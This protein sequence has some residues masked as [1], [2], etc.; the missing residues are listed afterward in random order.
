MSRSTVDAF[1]IGCRLDH[2]GKLDEVSQ[3][4]QQKV[5]TGLLRDKLHTQDFA[6]PISLRASVVHSQLF[7]CIATLL[8]LRSS[9]ASANPGA[10]HLMTCLCEPRTHQQDL[11]HR[12]DSTR[13]SSGGSV[14]SVRTRLF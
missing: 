10:F 3:D 2:D 9:N 6:G 13:Q 14:L 12:C 11:L 7:L 1:N 5:A 8:P 4:Q